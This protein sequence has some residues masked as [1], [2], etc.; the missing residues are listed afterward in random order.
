MSLLRTKMA[1]PTGPEPDA[2]KWRQSWGVIWKADGQPMMRNPLWHV[3][4]EPSAELALEKVSRWVT[5]G[6]PERVKD[7][8]NGVF[9][10]VRL[11]MAVRLRMDRRGEMKVEE[12]MTG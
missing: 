6:G 7:Y 8:W 9:Y 11:D 5:E 4:V 12:E 10:P 2:M 3:G 1:G